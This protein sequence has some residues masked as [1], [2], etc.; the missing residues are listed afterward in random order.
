VLVAGEDFTLADEY[1]E[2]GRGEF[3][4]VGGNGRSCASC[5]GPGKVA[6]DLVGAAAG[7]PKFSQAAGRIVD[8]AGRINACRDR[9]MDS[10]ALGRGTPKLNTLVSYAKYLS[11]GVA[12]DVA[13][14]GPAAEAIARGE[15]TFNKRAGQLNFSCASCHVPG[16]EGLWLRGQRLS[17]LD[18][19]A[20]DWPKHFIAGHDLGL[21]S[22]Q[23][24]TRH[25]Q[26]V[27]QTYPLPLGS[28]EYTELELY[29]TSLANGT[30]MWAPTKSR[31][32]GQ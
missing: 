28:Q 3:A 12:I 1:I 31:M 22:L 11:W 18:D 10:D 9:H 26:I 23:Q 13:T 29:L 27:T 21:I 8:L 16:R 7:Y 24:R 20:G 6:G 30:P 14:G 25:C 2:A 4:Q 15:Q 17:V 32:L 19:T 5:H